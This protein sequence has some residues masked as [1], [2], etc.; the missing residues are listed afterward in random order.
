MKAQVMR[1]AWE[2]VKA[3][4][5]T[6]GGKCR[7]YMSGALRRAWMEV[8]AMAE[9]KA[10]AGVAK[11]RVIGTMSGNDDAA[12]FTFKMWKNADESKKRIYVN[13]YKR[14]TI[15]YIDL[16]DNNKIVADCNDKYFQTIVNFMEEYA[17]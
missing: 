8:K 12:F 5:K 7:Q 15:G 6:F 14:R 9:K 3:A 2:L 13:D 11:V 10:F 17:F 16:M 4:V 1:R